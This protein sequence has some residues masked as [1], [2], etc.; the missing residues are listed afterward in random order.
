MREAKLRAFGVEFDDAWGS[1]WTL[2]SIPIMDPL[3]LFYGAYTSGSHYHIESMASAIGKLN[4]RFD[5]P[6]EELLA[7][8]PISVF[9]WKKI[10]VTFTDVAWGRAEPSG[11]WE[12]WKDVR[13]AWVFE[14]ARRLRIP[15]DRFSDQNGREILVPSWVRQ[16]LL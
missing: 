16:D 13:A 2:S 11:I 1:S 12:A 3:N 6:D 7:V 10:H 8:A 5:G 15:T 4:L 14:A 9:E